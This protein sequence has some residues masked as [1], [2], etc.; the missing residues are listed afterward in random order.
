MGFTYN[1]TIMKGLQKSGLLL[2][3]DPVVVSTKE[4]SLPLTVAVKAATGDTISVELSL[5]GG[6]N[7]D[8]W[9]NGDVTDSTIFDNRYSV[10]HSGITHLRFTRT[11]GTGTTSRWSLC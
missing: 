1:S 4:L 9:E 7:Y 2:D 8:D 3:G 10:F 6:I 5:D 11:A